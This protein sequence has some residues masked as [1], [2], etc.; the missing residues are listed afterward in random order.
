M[1]RVSV[2][3]FYADILSGAGFKARELKHSDELAELPFTTKSQLRD[4]YPL[5]LLAVERSEVRRI[6]ASSGTRG[7]PTIAAYTEGDLNTWADL[8]ARSLATVGVVPGDVV[9]N[10]YGYGLFTGG[11]GLHQGAERL[12]ATVIPSSSGRSQHQL[13]L[14]QDFGAR[15][16]C[17]TPSY[18]LTLASCIE[19][20]KID[21]STLKLEI[22]VLG[23]EPWSEEGRQHI[24]NRLGIKAYDI[25]GLSEIMGPGVAIECRAQVGL[26]IWEDHFFVEIINPQTGVRLPDGAAGELVITTLTKEAMPLLR[27]RTGDASAIIAEKCECGLPH[28]RIARLQGRFDDMLII[29]GVNVYPSEIESIIYSMEELG[30]D[31]QIV[32]DR[33]QTLD[34]LTVRVEVTQEFEH[35]A[36]RKQNVQRALIE[37]LKQRFGL[38]TQ[39][40]VMPHN[41]IPRSEGK[42][43]RVLDMRTP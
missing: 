3:P 37:M 35:D 29:R 43:T 36:V 32:V 12:G 19:E 1:Q 22:G 41:V 11:L 26:H 20:T 33:V 30:N 4:H 34:S 40:E 6:H 7:K 5:G 8:C 2:V 15:V 14:M 13:M 27:Y 21:R 31:Y 39:V 18:A 24:Q 16:L 42:A 17:C 38:T 9:Q 28:R 10:S 25:Y 23:A